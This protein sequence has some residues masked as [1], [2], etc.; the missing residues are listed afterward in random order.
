MKVRRSENQVTC[1]RP[2]THPTFLPSHLLTFFCWP[3]EPPFNSP[4]NKKGTPLVDVPLSFMIACATPYAGIT[5]VRFEGYTLS[6]YG[7][8]RIVYS[9]VGKAYV[10]VSP[11]SSE[12]L[13]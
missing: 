3:D 2:P 13:A 9:V 8:P 6:L 11:E 7:T 12:F 5:Q 1:I 10:R 4:S